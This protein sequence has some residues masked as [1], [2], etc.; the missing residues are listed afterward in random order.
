MLAPWAVMVNLLGSE[1][2]DPRDAYPEAM[3]LHPS[4][5]IHVYGKEVRPGRKLG[6]VTVCGDDLDA[7]RAQARETVEA[8]AGRGAP[9]TGATAAD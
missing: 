7:A 2:E 5:K 8:L 6:H 9:A 3:A 1:L 4:A